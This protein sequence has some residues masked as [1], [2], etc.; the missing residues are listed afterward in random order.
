MDKAN[1]LNDE[2]IDNLKAEI[3]SLK[4]EIN[5]MKLKQSKFE[6]DLQKVNDSNAKHLRAQQKKILFLMK[7]LLDHEKDDFDEDESDELTKVAQI[8]NSTIR[9]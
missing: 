4:F 5:E 3:I 9:F 1:D 7:R 6:S 8:K 2:I